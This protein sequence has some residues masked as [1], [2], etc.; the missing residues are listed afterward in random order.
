MSGLS[1]GLKGLSAEAQES[2]IS[3]LRGWHSR[4]LADRTCGDCDQLPKRGCH[5]QHRLKAA[6]RHSSGGVCKM[7]R[8]ISAL[9]AES[10]NGRVD[11]GWL[12][13]EA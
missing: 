3:G 1:D 6:N 10:L 12:S 5:D 13:V 11:D 9:T 7:F 8:A 4:W 2:E